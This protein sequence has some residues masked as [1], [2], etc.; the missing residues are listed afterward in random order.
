VDIFSKRNQFDPQIPKSPIAEDAPRIL[1]LE[2]W[3]RIL[4]PL[5][6]IDKDARYSK[7]DT[8]ILGRKS[9]LDDLCILLHIESNENMHD[10]WFCTD[11]LKNL[12]MDTPWYHFYDIIEGVAKQVS[13]IE[14]VFYPLFYKDN[15]NKVLENN[16]ITWRI[17]DTGFLVRASLEDLQ[18]KTEEVENIFQQGFPAALQ[19]LRKARRFITNRPLDP[20]NA[21]KEA[22]SAIES[23]GR[24]LYPNTSTLGDV[25]KEIRKTPFP[26]LILSMIEKFYAFASAEPGVRHGSSVSSKIDLADADFCLYISVAFADYLHKLYNK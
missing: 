21:I 3:S 22:V 23:Y 6:Y 17:D 14:D 20:E 13:E 11:E 5:S 24:A 25:I 2:Y 26:S 7:S 1:R 18:E 12:I 15:V 9:L 4:E 10:S 16:L 8:A 19:H